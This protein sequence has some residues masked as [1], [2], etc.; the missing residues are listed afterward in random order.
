MKL[1]SL[2]A[3]LCF[4]YFVLTISCQDSE[5]VI[6]YPE[7]GYAYL[8]AAND[9]DSTFFWDP[10]KDV[11]SKKDSFQTIYY[12]Y[13]YNFFGEQNLSIRPRDIPTFRLTFCNVIGPSAIIIL[14][15][16]Q[17]V[18]KIQTKGWAYP[19]F[20]TLKLSAV[21]RFDFDILNRFFPLDDS[22]RGRPH[23]KFLDSLINSN[24][25]LVD[26][27][28]FKYLVEKSADWGKEK[29][30]YSLTK[31][32]IS[33]KTFHY[34]VTRINESGYWK[35]PFNHLCRV[36]PNDVDG[37]ILEANTPYKY[38]VVDAL[39]CPNDSTDYM[40]ACDELITYAGLEKKE[41]GLVWDGTITPAKDEQ[42]QVSELTL[43]DLKQ[44]TIQKKKKSD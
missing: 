14:T 30:E 4:V 29:F 44:D 27:A 32:P 3:S 26:P 11:L 39:I 9:K 2:I 5:K 41:F 36:I 19:D 12:N 18:T 10:L 35:L 17:I 6:A 31:I 23:R 37:F 38:H 15:P 28:Y 20:D 16:T 8:K 13:L 42:I 33:K 34:L 25:K 7:G 40:K 1:L 43:D 24:P 21:E 22:T